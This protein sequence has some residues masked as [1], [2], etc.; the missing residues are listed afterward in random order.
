M[1]SL[2]TKFAVGVFVALGIGLAVI[3]VIWLGMSH[4]LEEGHYYAAFFDESVQGL[5]IDSPVKYRGFTIGRVDSIGVAPDSNLIQVILKIESD[6]KPEP[7]TVAQLKSV[8]I[9]GIMYVELE[10]RKPNEP[11]LSPEINFT[12]K[13]PTIATKPSDIKKL[14][15]GIEDVVV[16]FQSLDAPVIS[17]KIKTILNKIDQSIDDTQIKDISTDIRLSLGTIQNILE[18]NRMNNI[19]TSVEKAG[20]NLDV[21]SSN[22]NETV[23]SVKRII[24][25]NEKKIIEAINEFKQATNQMNSF[26]KNGTEMVIGTN[27][28]ITILQSRLMIILRNLERT[29]ENLNRLTD[30]SA[31]Q[32]SQLFFGEPIPPKKIETD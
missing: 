30:I 27:E 23:L 24:S 8:G 7:D 5:D 31:D 2:K 14:F 22:A 15:D 20:A 10:K 12:V 29:S 11:D 9:T 25:G 28:S 32:P 6:I 16:Q 4:Y 26:L 19:L 21:L 17:D 1:A 18:S 3:A 13:Y